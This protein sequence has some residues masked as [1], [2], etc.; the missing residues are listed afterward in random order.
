M[1]LALPWQPHL[2]T[3]RQAFPGSTHQEEENPVRGS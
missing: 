1:P 2:L 3:T